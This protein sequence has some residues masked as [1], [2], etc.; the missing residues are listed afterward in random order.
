[1]QSEAVGLPGFSLISDGL[2]RLVHTGFQSGGNGK[3]RLED[4]RQGGDTRYIL[5]VSV[6][7]KLL[8][9]IS[10]RAHISAT[11]RLLPACLP[12]CGW[13]VCAFA[14]VFRVVRLPRTHTVQ[15]RAAKRPGASHA[16]YSYYC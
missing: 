6:P 3:T 9:F 4:V 11:A 13:L 2:L 16:Y 8:C 10:V 5:A 15:G 7:F 1:M 14:W 12:A